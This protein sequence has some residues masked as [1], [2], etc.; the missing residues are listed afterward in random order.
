MRRAPIATDYAR[1]AAL[2]TATLRP[3]ANPANQDVDSETYL[4]E[5]EEEWNKKIDEQVAILVHNMV[6]LV[7][8][9]KVENKDHFRASQEAFQAELKAESMVQATSSLLSLT[10][11]L[12]LM[13]LLSDEREIAQR[14]EDEIKTLRQEIDVAKAR[15]VELWEELS[16][17]GPMPTDPSIINVP[18]EAMDT[19]A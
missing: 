1:P 18:G 13:L 3:N 7:E 17:P 5:V 10:H 19:G 14:R 15:A 6:D 8:I 4:R 11:S 12:K 16:I 9:A 2:P